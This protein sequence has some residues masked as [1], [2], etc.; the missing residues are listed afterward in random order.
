MWGAQPQNSTSVAECWTVVPVA[1]SYRVERS[2][3]GGT[4]WVIA[5]QGPYK[6][7]YAECLVDVGL[8]SEQRVCYRAFAQNSLG[9]SAPSTVD[10]TTPLAGPTNVAA[11][12]TAAGTV[13]LTWTDN[14]SAETGYSITRCFPYAYEPACVDVADLPANTTSF[15]DTVDAS[16][17]SDVATYGVFATLNQGWSDVVEVTVV[18][19]LVPANALA[20]PL[21]P[22]QIHLEWLDYSSALHTVRID[23]CA[24]DVASCADASFATIV[25]L[26]AWPPSYDD[27][28]LQPGTTH[29]YRI[30][31]VNEFGTSAPATAFATTAL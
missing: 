4:T 30:R 10:C 9:E 8:T 22:T 23:R 16:W 2:V 15:V 28:G 12:F 29:T 26:Q 13:E 20:S 17:T 24:G 19:A 5:V 3:D 1:N 31:F 6:S 7:W 27:S 11:K 21:S 14:S 25:E 18:V